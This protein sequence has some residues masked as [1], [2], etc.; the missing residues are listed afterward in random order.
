MRITFY[1]VSNTAGAFRDDWNAEEGDDRDGQ[2]AGFESPLVYEVDLFF[3]NAPITN[4]TG[5]TDWSLY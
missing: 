4:P 3:G 1:Q 2:D 5:V